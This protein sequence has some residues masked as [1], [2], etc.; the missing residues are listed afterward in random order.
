MLCLSVCHWNSTPRAL[1]RCVARPCFRHSH[2]RNPLPDLN[3]PQYAASVYGCHTGRLE[4]VFV[5]VVDRARNI[6]HI[7]WINVCGQVS[8]ATATARLAQSVDRKAL[9][10]VVVV[11]SPTVGGAEALCALVKCL[12]LG[13]KYQCIYICIPHTTLFMHTT[14]PHPN[15]AGLRHCLS[16]T[17]CVAPHHK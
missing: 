13:V 14:Y 3:V 7:C 16:C 11:S 12:W 4:Q 8:A 5:L 10:L 17:S 15:S 2:V 6:H 9:N 1:G